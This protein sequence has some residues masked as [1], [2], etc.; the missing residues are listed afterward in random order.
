MLQSQ[1]QVGLHVVFSTKN[2][3]AYLEEP[4]FRDQ[5]FRLLA[6]HVKEVGCVVAIVG[7]HVDH[8]E[9]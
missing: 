8:V 6:H 3:R 9:E 5:M 4:D 2:R 1:A 7:G